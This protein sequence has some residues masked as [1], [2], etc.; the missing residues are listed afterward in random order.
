MTDRNS[1][2]TILRNYKRDNARKYGIIDLGLF[3]SVA[4]QSAGEHSD[5]DVCV[6][7]ETPD[8]YILVHIRED[9]ERMVHAHVD[10]VRVRKN[11]NSLLKARIEQEGV[12]V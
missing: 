4:R 12:Y 9:L 8:P 11:M 5:V 6:K 3:G 1:V 10:I 7:T 2:L